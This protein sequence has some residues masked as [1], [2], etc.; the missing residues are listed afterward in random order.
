MAG[1]IFLGLILAAGAVIYFCQV[2]RDSEYEGTYPGITPM[3]QA[4]FEFQDDRVVISLSD[5]PLLKRIVVF[6]YDDKNRQVGIIKPV[7]DKTVVL[8]PDEFPDFRVYFKENTVEGYEIV[9]KVKG[10]VN[11]EDFFET[12]KRARAASRRYGVQQCLYPICTICLDVCPVI[13][14]GVIEMR[15]ASDGRIHPFIHLG[16][17]PRCGKCFE[18]CKLGVLYKSDLRHIQNVPPDTKSI[19]LQ[20]DPKLLRR[21]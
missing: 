21:E 2:N 16:S 17:C 14:N 11:G 18:V 20:G 9:K 12:M 15:L 6:A 1:F 5:E 4:A 10:V 7:Y 3:I 19:I 8:T 13:Q